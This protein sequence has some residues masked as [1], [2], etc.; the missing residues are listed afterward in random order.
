MISSCVVYV[1]R[2]FRRSWI[3]FC[4]SFE[5]P[6]L[7]FYGSASSSE[8]PKSLAAGRPAPTLRGG[9]DL[10]VFLG[11]C[12]DRSRTK[13]IS[14]IY[15]YISK[16]CQLSTEHDGKGFM[17]LFPI[18]PSLL[19]GKFKK[20]SISPKIVLWPAITRS[21]IYLG[22]KNIPPIASTHREQ[23][24][25]PCCEMLRRLVSKRQGGRIAPSPC[26]DVLWKMSCHGE[27]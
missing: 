22:S 15:I 18:A 17:A 4:Y 12:S 27:G 5:T 8:L 9:R 21:N 2:G 11:L 20:T 25:C 14:Y 3:R 6:S 7:H 10:A 19:S 23:S 13:A 26:Q 24:V 1:Y 16:W